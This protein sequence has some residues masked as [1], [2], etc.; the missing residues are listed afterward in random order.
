ELRDSVRVVA[1]PCY[2]LPGCD[3]PLYCSMIVV[4]ADSRAREIPDLRG[5]RVAINDRNSQSGMNA[6]RAI[7]APIAGGAPFFDKIM[8][9]GSHLGSLAMVREGRADVAAIDCVT[10]GLVAEG[11]PDLLRGTRVLCRTPLVPGLPLVTSTATSDAVLARLIAALESTMTDPDLADIRTSLHLR[12]I[13]RLG[14]ADYAP[15]LAQRDVAEA[16]GY[17]VLC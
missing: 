4:G 10:H 3:G 7:V 16:S 11:N 2:D 15:I 8:V 17:Q 12:G 14:F 13:A 5:G 9:S 6:L 1:T